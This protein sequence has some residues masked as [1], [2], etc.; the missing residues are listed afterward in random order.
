VVAALAGLTPDTK[1]VPRMSAAADAT[2]VAR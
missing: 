2:A 1:T